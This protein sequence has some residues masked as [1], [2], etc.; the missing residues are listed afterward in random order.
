[1]ITAGQRDQLQLIVDACPSPMCVTSVDTHQVITGNLGFAAFFERPLAQLIG[2]TGATLFSSDEERGR[3]RALL[4]TAQ[5]YEDEELLFCKLDGSQF[6]GLVS[7]RTLVVEGLRVVTT[8]F[9][10]IGRYKQAEVALHDAEARAGQ[11]E[12]HIDALTESMTLPFFITSPGTGAVLFV[13]QRTA[14]TFGST[15]GELLKRRSPEFYFEPTEREQ[16]V[17]QIR[18]SGRVIDFELRLRRANG[19]PFYALMSAAAT[20][21]KGEPAVIA[22]VF[23]LTR[24]KQ[25]ELELRQAQKLESL[26]R[27]ASG[28]AHEINTPMQYIGNNLQFAHQTVGH[29]AELS[30]RLRT[31]KKLV[32]TGADAKAALAAVEAHEQEADLDFALEKLPIALGEALSGVDRVASIVRAMQGFALPEQLEKAPADLNAGIRDTLEVAQHE[33]KGVARVETRLATLPLVLCSAGEV[34]QVVLNLV[35]NAAH[36]ISARRKPGE[37]PGTITVTSRLDA[38]EVEVSVSD[39]GSG[40]A[41]EIRERVFDP[42]FTTQEVGHGT[43]QGL[44]ICRNVIC[45]KHGGKLWFETEVGRGT[46]FY[47]RLPVQP[48]S[49]HARAA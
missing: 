15:V 26:G 46:T 33:Y 44:S 35:V 11:S 31:L 6:W 36:A 34:N 42:F 41:P 49:P 38:G 19:D 14:D 1:M 13:N 30:R 2:L 32:A 8:T 16:L 12:E 25:L 47:F 10:D 48:D 37:P 39:D 28:L 45:T 40:I 43:G 21:Y 23:D 5:H 24:H 4:K 9:Q 29:L 17:H 3:I 27:L 22:T 18:T 20:R 7:S